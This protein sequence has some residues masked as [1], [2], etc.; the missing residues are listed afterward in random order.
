[1][2]EKSAL[3]DGGLSKESLKSM[4]I[5]PKNDKSKKGGL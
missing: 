5:A 4:E 3:L 2:S 1:M